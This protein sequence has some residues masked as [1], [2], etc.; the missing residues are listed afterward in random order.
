MPE[1]SHTSEAIAAARKRFLELVH[2]IEPHFLK[3]L[4]LE[5]FHI[6]FSWQNTQR[7]IEHEID[8]KNIHNLHSLLQNHFED[9]GEEKL[10]QK[11][12]STLEPVGHLIIA[13]DVGGYS[14]LLRL[15]PEEW[16]VYYK[17]DP[18]G[19]ERPCWA[20]KKLFQGF[21]TR[22][23]HLLDEYG[24]NEE[25]QKDQAIDQIEG[26]YRRASLDP[27]AVD[28]WDPNEGWL[29][30]SLSL[31]PALQ[32]TTIDIPPI[33]VEWD[34][35]TD[36]EEARES[37]KKRILSYV[38]DAI[39]R[40]DQHFDALRGPEKRGPDPDRHLRWLVQR[41][42]LGESTKTIASEEGKAERTIRDGIKK[43]NLLV[44]IKQL[45]PSRRSR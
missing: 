13:A 43:A 7:E 15:L 38:E 20:D 29:H 30:L 23:D 31:S 28:K 45:R 2:E 16:H 32:G 19:S 42:I 6:Y 34:R 22:L 33:T 18:L 25:W 40:V 11:K 24:M 36:L 10:R 35:L 3:K 39:D 14:E 41:Q 12:G 21:E 44:G 8:I 27:S 37:E 9:V 4:K 1:Q 5:V 17:K 26:W